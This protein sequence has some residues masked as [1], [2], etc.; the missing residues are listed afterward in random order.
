[1]VNSIL[2]LATARLGRSRSRAAGEYLGCIH[3]VLSN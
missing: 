1:M 2:D 3:P